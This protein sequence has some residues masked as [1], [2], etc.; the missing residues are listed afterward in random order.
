MPILWLKRFSPFAPFLR[1]NDGGGYDLA[2]K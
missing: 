1:F 2:T